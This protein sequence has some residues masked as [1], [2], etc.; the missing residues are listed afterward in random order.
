MILTA[1]YAKYAKGAVSGQDEQD[2]L[3]KI[4]P[5]FNRGWTGVALFCPPPFHLRQRIRRDE[6]AGGGQKRAKFYGD[7]YPG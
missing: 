1:K 4:F 3:D 5:G 2:L 6:P 7:V